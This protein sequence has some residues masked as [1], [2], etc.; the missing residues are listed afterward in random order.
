MGRAFACSGAK[1]RFVGK[2]TGPVVAEGG[3]LLL[4]ITHTI[5]ETA[6]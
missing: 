1:V 2:E 3:G 5:D 4:G 6:P